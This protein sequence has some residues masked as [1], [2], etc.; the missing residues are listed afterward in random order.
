MQIPTTQEKRAI[1]TVCSLYMLRMLGLFM[2]LPVFSLYASEVPWSTPALMG[3]AMGIYGLTQGLLQIPFGIASDRFGRQR[4]LNIGLGLFV[5]GSLVGIMAQTIYGLILARA[6]QGAGAIGSVILATLSDCTR[7]QIRARAMGMVGISIGISFLGAFWGGPLLAERFGLTGIFMVCALLGIAALCLLNGQKIVFLKQT[8]M[9][10]PA[11]KI[12][13]G[14]MLKSKQMLQDPN[15]SGYYGGIFVL[16]AVLVALFLVVPDLLKDST[17]WFSKQ[18]FV[19]VGVLLGALLVAMPLLFIAER[20]A[21][22]T[23]LFLGGL[24]LLWAG[25][26]GL[27]VGASVVWGLWVFFIGFT[28][29]EALFPS[30]VSIVAPK[31]SKGMALG[32]YSSFQFLGIF[33]GG[34]MGGWLNN[35]YGKMAVLTF[36]VIITGSFTLWMFYKL[37]VQHYVKRC[38]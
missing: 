14:I 6:L 30:F 25:L 28:V 21:K 22:K 33:C 4:L 34:L 19:Y 15:L 11:E 10:D 32:V 24:L 31:R 36:S 38:Q 12:S 37:G 16:H 8:V 7:E 29:L 5:L 13:D 2:I 3:W 27:R 9:L 17:A 18:S 26:V 35:E 23:A 20:Y 1:F